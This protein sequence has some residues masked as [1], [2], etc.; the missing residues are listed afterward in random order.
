MPLLQLPRTQGC[1]VCGR[2]NPIG[3]HLTSFVDDA[4]GVISNHFTPTAHHIGFHGVIHGGLLATVLDEAMVWAATWAGKRFCLAAEM[5]I[6][7]KA[8]ARVGA[9][10]TTEARIDFARTRLVTT[11]GVIREGEVVI[12]EATGK[13]MPLS[14]EE[15][16]KFV[17]T[18]VD[19]PASDEAAA[20][21][22]L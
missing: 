5:T 19:D 4:S 21:L 3:L 8:P 6:R 2:D 17:A 15:S 22:R 16:A 7:F 14:I 18:L 9:D 11:T 10:L 1:L 12:A 13:Y 20:M